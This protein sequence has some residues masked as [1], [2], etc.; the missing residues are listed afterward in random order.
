MNRLKDHGATVR[1][2]TPPWDKK[3]LKDTI[4]RGPLKLADQC[5]NFLREGLL[6]FVQKGFWV[7][8]PYKLLTKFK[9]I[10]NSLQI[11]PMGVVP[12]QAWRPRIIADCSFFGLS[13]S[14]PEWREKDT[15]SKE[16]TVEIRPEKE[17][18]GILA[19]LELFKTV[20][21]ARTKDLNK[22]R[23]KRNPG[24]SPIKNGLE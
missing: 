4:A 18:R 16:R 14:A 8:L 17:K 10:R 15:A 23:Q 11:R 5:A 24:D 3:R 9:Q 1:L 19:E 6:D 21:A 22:L 7:V 20:K 2:S 12:Q 13:N